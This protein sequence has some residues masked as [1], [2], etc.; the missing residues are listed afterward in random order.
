MKTKIN[1]TLLLLITG[2]H[3]IHAHEWGYVNTLTDEWLRKICM[4]GLD[5]VYIVGENG[6]IAQ[7][8]DQGE[9]WNKQYFPI[10]VT[11]NDIIFTDHYTGFAV[12]EQGTIL[13]TNNAGDNWTQVILNVTSNI[14]AIAATGPNNIW[15]VGDNS[16]ILHSIDSGDTW[17][18]LNILSENNRQLSDIEFRDNLGYFT[19]NYATVYKTEDYGNNWNK[20]T[21]KESF[22]T[23]DEFRSINITEGKTYI[24]FGTQLFFTEDQINWNNNEEFPNFSTISNA[25]GL[26]YLDANQGYHTFTFDASTTSGWSGYFPEIRRIKDDWSEWHSVDYHWNS[27][28][29]VSYPS[30]PSCL[31]IRLVNDTLGYATFGTRLLKLPYRPDYNSIKHISVER[32]ISIEYL[33]KNELFIKSNISPVIAIEVFDTYGN[34]LMKKEWQNPV[35]K[36]NINTGNFVNGVYLMKVIFSNNN[37]ETVKWIKH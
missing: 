33:S 1:F 19:G 13:K 20:Q 35:E 22:N 16:L 17:Q 15:A 18:Q 8:T 6:L 24:R 14:N 21:L 32:K 25:R 5:T 26:F 7:S 2:I 12:G 10:G 28:K 34:K 29:Q 23:V 9:T 31:D 27:I 36:T 30:N 4:Q 3:A 11:L 37:T